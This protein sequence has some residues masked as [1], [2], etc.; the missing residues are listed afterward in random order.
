MAYQPPDLYQLL[1][2]IAKQGKTRQVPKSC[3]DSLNRVDREIKAIQNNFIPI[4]DL[5][6][7]HVGGELWG[8]AIVGEQHWVNSRETGCTSKILTITTI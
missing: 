8:P 3:N 2:I 1:S 5:H 6:V 4:L 7:R